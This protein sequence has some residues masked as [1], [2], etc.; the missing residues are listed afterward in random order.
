MPELKPQDLPNERFVR[1]SVDI[2]GRRQAQES[3]PS[4]CRSNGEDHRGPDSLEPIA[5]VQSR[6]LS[7]H[8][9]ECLSQGT[10]QQ[11]S[12]TGPELLDSPAVARPKQ[13]R[14]SLQAPEDQAARFAN[15]I[16]DATNTDSDCDEFLHGELRTF[17]FSWYLRERLISSHLS[18]LQHSRNTAAFCQ[19]L[20]NIASDNIASLLCR[21]CLRRICTTTARTSHPCQQHFKRQGA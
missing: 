16:C 8:Q 20:S 13:A 14:R 18:S 5:Y 19:S 11:A 15:L 9:A 3:F 10:M 2:M 4:I 17:I 7:R 21:L 1:K 12:P 6:N